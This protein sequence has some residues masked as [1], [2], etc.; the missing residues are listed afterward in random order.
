MIH[1]KDLL[2]SLRVVQINTK[3]KSVSGAP[4]LYVLKEIN[5]GCVF[6]YLSSS[7]FLVGDKISSDHLKDAITP[8]L[9]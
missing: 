5:C 4:K 3:K 2:K 1:N 9:K 8:L 7:F 6:C